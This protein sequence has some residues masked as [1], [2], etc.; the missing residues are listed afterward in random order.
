M[1]RFA[2]ALITLSLISGHI[3]AYADVINIQVNISG[4]ANARGQIALAV[5]DNKESYTNYQGA[6]ASALIPASSNSVTFHALQNK[7]YAVVAFHDENG[8]GEMNMEQQIPLEGYGVSGMQRSWQQP[9]FSQA[10]AM[11]SQVD[12]ELFYLK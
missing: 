2:R 4:Q 11:R 3:G 10:A 9:D 7:P 1:F 6:I 12:I 5:F 8:D